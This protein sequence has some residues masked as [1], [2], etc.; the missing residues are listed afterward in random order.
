MF[1]TEASHVRMLKVLYK[2]FYKSLQ[3]SQL[4][5]PEELNLIFPNIKELLDIHTKFNNEVRQ[6]RKDDPLVRQIGDML[7]SAFSGKTLHFRVFLN[8]NCALNEL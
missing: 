7:L 3:S 6:R 4:L 5:K 8:F 1:L 2:N